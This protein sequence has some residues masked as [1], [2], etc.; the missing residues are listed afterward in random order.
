MK[1]TLSALVAVLLV[2]SAPMA[3]AE[4][5][6]AAA[7]EEKQAEK[8]EKQAEKQQQKRERIDQVAK[9]TL[10]RLFD[11][12]E[13]AKELYD[14]AVGYAVFDNT[15]VTFVIS[16]GGG[17]GVVVDKKTKARTYMN[18]GTGGLAL[19]LGA[20]VYQVVFLFQDS[21]TFTDFV[22]SG[23]SAEGSANAV[24]GTAGANAEASFVNGV[25]VFQLTQA[26]LLLQA[27]ISGTKYWKSD[28]LN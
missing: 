7:K 11:E 13:K 3:W 25:A 21:K 19:G 9:D 10:A 23:W 24:A 18:M 15:K 12:S 8:A 16:G 26:G 28:A 22:E 20:Q 2:L 5:D 4:D 1:K 17:S 6:K 14:N 27:D